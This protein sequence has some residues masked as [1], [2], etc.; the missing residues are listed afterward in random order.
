MQWADAATLDLLLYLARSLADHSA[1]V[2]LLLT[3]RTGADPLP[4]VQSTWL[5]ALKRT[6]IPLTALALAVF[7]R[8]DERRTMVALDNARGADADHAPMPAFAV[9]DQA[10]GVL[11]LGR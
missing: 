9:D 2:L 8:E 10:V 11:Q 1:P 5:M 6:H 4:G 7:T 3:L